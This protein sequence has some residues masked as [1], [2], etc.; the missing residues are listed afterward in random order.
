MGGIQ[1]FCGGDEKEAERML[2]KERV[3]WDLMG[4]P[5]K[6]PHDPTETWRGHLYPLLVIAVFTARRCETYGL[7]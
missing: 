4:P 7:R 6:N 3:P 2:T 5:P 1:E